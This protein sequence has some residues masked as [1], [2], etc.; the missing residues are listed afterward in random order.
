MTLGGLLRHLAL[1]E[2]DYFSGK[3]F[4]EP[5]LPPFDAVDFDADPRLG[6]AYGGG[7]V[8]R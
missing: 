4:D 7:R 2:E 1:M 8:A 5:L 3:L 6:V